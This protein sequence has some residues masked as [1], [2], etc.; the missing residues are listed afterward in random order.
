MGNQPSV[1]SSAELR[2]SCGPLPPDTST[3]PSR[4][5]AAAHSP[6]G[7]FI[8][9]VDRNGRTRIVDLGASQEFRP[10]IP[11]G[12]SASRHR[13]EEDASS[14]SRATQ[15]KSLSVAIEPVAENVLTWDRTALRTSC[16]DR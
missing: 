8:E 6:R 1:N 10:S 15:P 4:S 7:W 12:S 11:K 13:G 9:A 14:A 16:R 5:N 2:A 3:R